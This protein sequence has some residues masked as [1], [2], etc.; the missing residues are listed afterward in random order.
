MS[1]PEPIVFSP[2]HLDEID[3]GLLR[4]YDFQPHLWHS[5][6]RKLVDRYMITQEWLH[7]LAHPDYTSDELFV[8]LSQCYTSMDMWSARTQHLLQLIA[9]H[10]IQLRPVLQTF[11]L[12]QR[13]EWF[14]HRLELAQLAHHH[15]YTGDEAL[16]SYLSS[17]PGFTYRPDSLV[18]HTW[19]ELTE[20]THTYV[21][22][23]LQQQLL[24]PK[25]FIQLGTQLRMEHCQSSAFYALHVLNQLKSMEQPRVLL[26][27]R[28]P[29]RSHVETFFKPY[30]FHQPL[31]CYY[32]N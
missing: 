19:S 3:P 23:G 27:G 25:D 7:A 1:Q 17:L 15:I 12:T 5:E 30:R 4:L 10:L 11:P 9:P 8:F 14:F 2:V 29:Q 18:G 13:L 26:T 6:P 20:D 24:S 32:Q 21:C 22:M 28:L 31:H 16:G